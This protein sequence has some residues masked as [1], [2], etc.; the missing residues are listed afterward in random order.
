MTSIPAQRAVVITARVTA[1]LLA[2]PATAMLFT[3]EVDWGLGDFVVAAVLLF[4][5][6]MAI[7]AGARFTRTAAQ[8]LA[9]VATVLIALALVW[10]ELAVGLFH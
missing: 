3:R 9:A 5:A 10:A 6:G 2:V 4:G 7:Y 1:A 8:R